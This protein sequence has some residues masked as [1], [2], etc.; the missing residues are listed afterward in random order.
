[1]HIPS[2]VRVGSCD[3]TVGFVEHALTLNGQ[4][5]LGIVDCNM[6]RISI[7]RTLGDQQQ[8]EQTFLHELLHAVVNERGLELDNEEL[9]VNELAKGLHQVI[10]DNPML[11]RA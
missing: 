6:H 5:C 11:F 10:R 3:Y 4:E 2:N 7:N 8:R 9:V 1:M